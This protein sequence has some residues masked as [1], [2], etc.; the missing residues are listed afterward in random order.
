VGYSKKQFIDAAFEEIGLA[1]YTFDVSPEQEESALRLLDSMMAEWNASGVRIAY[2][3]SDPDNSEIDAPTNVPDAAYEAIR[4]NLALKLAPQY[5][6]Q[7]MPATMRSGNQALQVL[8]ARFAVPPIA[9][10]RPGTP[11]GAGN[12]AL[13]FGRGPFIQNPPV[14]DAGPDQPLEYV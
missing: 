6:R 12:W 5:G 2:P 9:P 1:R 13:G 14:V 3:L 7:V 4:T 10:Y 8:R 11:L